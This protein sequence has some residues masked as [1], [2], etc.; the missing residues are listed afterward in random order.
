MS[1]LSDVMLCFDG[2]YDDSVTLPLHCSGLAVM[3]HSLT[4]LLRGVGGVL[5]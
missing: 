3:S 1:G 4:P 2:Q 5:L